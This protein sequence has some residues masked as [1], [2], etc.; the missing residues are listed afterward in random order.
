MILTPDDIHNAARHTGG[1]AV[2][3]Q[4]SKINYDWNKTIR[5]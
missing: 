2:I 1:A 5:Q 3:K 4:N